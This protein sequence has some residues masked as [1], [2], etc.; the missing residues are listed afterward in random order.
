MVSDEAR[1]VDDRDGRPLSDIHRPVLDRS[2]P[3]MGLSGIRTQGVWVEAPQISEAVLDE[4]LDF[5]LVPQTDPSG[6]NAKG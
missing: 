4:F 5:V 2:S 1:E 3:D 6:H